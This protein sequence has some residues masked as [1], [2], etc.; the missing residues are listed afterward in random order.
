MRIPQIL[1][2]A[3]TIA[4][5][6]AV[7][8]SAGAQPPTAQIIGGTTVPARRR[9]V[10]RVFIEATTFACSG[11]LVAPQWVLTAGHCAFD[12][13]R[14]SPGSAGR[15]P[16][17]RRHL[18]LDDGHA[19]AQILA[20]TEVHPYPYYNHTTLQG[21][22]ALLEARPRRHR[23]RRERSRSPPPHSLRCTRP[24]SRSPRWAGAS[25]RRRPDAAVPNTSAD[26]HR[27]HPVERDLRCRLVRRAVLPG[28][29]HVRLGA[30][31]HAIHL[32]R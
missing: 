8:S 25:R 20:V 26:G 32:P 30:G 1:S 23:H 22:A 11:S 31:L 21:D 2:A 24:G 29:R 7:V 15:V 17:G 14:S 3:C 16:R 5:G 12:D 6:L 19:G 4:V 13:K 10:R 18:G 28:L 27:R 9:P